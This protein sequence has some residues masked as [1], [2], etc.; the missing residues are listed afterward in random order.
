MALAGAFL[1]LARQHAGTARDHRGP[2]KSRFI[3]RLQPEWDTKQVMGVN[4][5]WMRL[6]NT[7]LLD[8]RA[9]CTTVK[10]GMLSLLLDCDLCP[11]TQ[12]PLFIHV[13]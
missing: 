11:C 1:L 9:P 3:F 4:L 12:V 10:H 2:A 5:S 6:R 13:A 7:A 8:G